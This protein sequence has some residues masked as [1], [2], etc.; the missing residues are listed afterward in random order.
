L[1]ASSAHR[2]LACPGSF[3]LCRRAPPSRPSVHAARGT[4]AHALIEEA[5]QTRAQRIDKLLD[6]Q[7]Q[8]DGYDLVVD[9]EM[10]EGVHIML[11][12]VN[13]A[14]GDYEQVMSE[15]LV[16]LDKC[17]TGQRP[18]PVLMFGRTDVLM[19]SL[20]RRALEIVDFKNGAGVTVEPEMNPQELYYAAGVLCML[21]DNAVHQVKLT[22]VQPHVRHRDKVRSSVIDVI[23]LWMWIED[24]LLP[25][26]R[27]AEASDA[28][29]VPGFYCRFCPASLM[30]SALHDA[31]V[32]MAKHEFSD[33]ALSL[34][35]TPDKLADALDLAARAETWIEAVRAHAIE[36]LKSQVRIPHWGLVPTRPT[37]KW[38]SETEVT[39][40][41]RS[42]LEDTDVFA[43]TLRSPAQL[44]KIV[45][46]KLGNDTWD[47]LS[48]TQVLSVSSG[49]K[50]Q[51][52]G[53]DL[54]EEE[55]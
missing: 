23:D 31:A 42:L 26:V 51:R 46:R 27:A 40:T 10:I 13:Q 32:A 14:R 17:F 15:T 20:A 47:V 22:V 43:T 11:D 41:L 25:G 12:Y 55:F 8:I 3:N 52:D 16:Q 9:D 6:T 33:D 54:A 21:P 35:E 2:W 28:A 49:V 37:R 48:Q 44:E 34:P 1:G 19:L 18:P 36:Q 7:V 38:R 53:Q 5:L 45:R 30:C 24:V 4:L 29:L 39:G 50:L